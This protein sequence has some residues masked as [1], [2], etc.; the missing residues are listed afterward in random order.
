[1]DFFTRAFHFK[2]RSGRQDLIIGIVLF[3]CVLLITII[4]D[5]E[6]Q[7]ILNLLLMIIYLIVLLFCI[8]ALISLE[9][10]RLHDLGY[11]GWWILCIM[12]PIINIPLWCILIFKKGEATENKYGKPIGITDSK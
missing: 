3:Y 5:T 10:R 7:D 11:S 6:S 2:G 1:M 9:I 12:I 8:I 4:L